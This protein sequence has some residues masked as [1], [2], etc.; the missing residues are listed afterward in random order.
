MTRYDKFNFVI[1]L[2]L[3]ASIYYEIAFYDAF[4]LSN[5]RVVD[6]NVVNINGERTINLS[7]YR[8]LNNPA[9]F[10]NPQAFD[11]NSPQIFAQDFLTEAP[12]VFFFWANDYNI[13]RAS[14]FF[15]YLRHNYLNCKLVCWITNPIYYYQRVQKIFV[16]KSTTDEFLSTFDLVLTYNQVDAMD[17]GLTYFEGPYTVLPFKQLQENFDIFFVG[18]PKDRLEKILRAY[19]SFKAAGFVCDFYI[20]HINNPPIK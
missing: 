19:E 9:A 10:K 16:D 11:V 8:P 13:F 3:P 6:F 20:N 5:V 4:A 18:R 14:K 15:Y 1:F 12:I 7:P 17:Y 2:S